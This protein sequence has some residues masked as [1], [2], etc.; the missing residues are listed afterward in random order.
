MEAVSVA[1][2]RLRK[3]LRGRSE[4]ESLPRV[5][6]AVFRRRG[7]G[8]GRDDAIALASRLLLLDPDATLFGAQ[9]RSGTIKLT[10]GAVTS[11]RGVLGQSAAALHFDALASA[12][13]ADTW[14]A[15]TRMIES[16]I[17]ESG[18]AASFDQAVFSKFV[19]DIYNSGNEDRRQCLLNVLGKTDVPSE[20]LGHCFLRLGHDVMDQFIG[21]ALPRER[22]K[23]AIEAAHELMFSCLADPALPPAPFAQTVAQLVKYNDRQRLDDLRRLLRSGR[24]GPLTEK[25]AHCLAELG[26][27][28][29][30]SLFQGVVSGHEHADGVPLSVDLV[31]QRD[32][33]S[34]AP[35]SHI[36]N[37]VSYAV[38]YGNARN[39]DDLSTRLP[40][41][42]QAPASD[43][44]VV[45]SDTAHLA[46]LSERPNFYSGINW[47]QPR[48]HFF[49]VSINFLPPFITTIYVQD[50][51]FYLTTLLK[52]GHY[53]RVA[54]SAI[55]VF[56]V[57]DGVVV[58]RPMHFDDDTVGGSQDPVLSDLPDAA[59]VEPI[60]WCNL[61]CQYCH[62]SFMHDHKPDRITAEE[63][64]H[65]SQ[66]RGKFVQIGAAYEPTLNKDFHKFVDLFSENG[67]ELGVIT[68]GSLLNEESIESLVKSN[69]YA[70]QFSFD[71]GT[72][73]TYELIRRL[74]NFETSIGNIRRLKQR[75]REEGKATFINLSVVLM[76]ANIDEIPA[77]IDLAEDL[78]VDGLGF[79]FMVLRFASD[80]ALIAQ[81]LDAQ[82]HYAYEKLDE[83]AE[84]AIRTGKT[85]VL[86]CSYFAQTP[87]RARYPE[88]CAIPGLVIPRPERGFRTY[89]NKYVLSQIGKHPLMEHNCVS[90]F[91]FAR[92]NADGDVS[93]CRDFIIGNVK[94]TDLRDV[95]HSDTARFVRGFLIEN[96][97]VCRACEHYKYCLQPAKVDMHDPKHYGNNVTLGSDI[98]AKV[99]A[100]KLDELLH[101][102]RIS[103]EFKKAMRHAREGDGVAL[104]RLVAGSP[105]VEAAD[106]Y[107][108]TLLHR[109]VAFDCSPEIV[110]AL[111]DCGCDVNA[112]NRTEETPLL[113]AAHAGNEAVIRL[114]LSRGAERTP[115]L[116]YAVG[117]DQREL[118]AFLV[119]HGADVNAPI[120]NTGTVLWV[121]M[122]NG[123]DRMVR[124]LIDQKADLSVVGAEGVSPLAW[125]AVVGN[126]EWA[127]A[128]LE[129]GADPNGIDENGSTPLIHA[130]AQGAQGVA[131]ILVDRGARL[132]W[133]NAAGEDA[134]LI[135]LREHHWSTADYLIRHGAD[136]VCSLT[137][138]QA[139]SDPSVSAY[140]AQSIVQTG[141]AQI[142]E[143][144]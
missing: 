58:E 137:R 95:W 39:L 131:E 134:L 53:P 33:H 106:P 144:A 10:P 89:A 20:L 2:K 66:L 9:L 30:L 115:A 130:A 3:L 83:G 84:Y 136:L 140:L 17:I 132:D 73:P 108:N 102:E 24:L 93:L 71:A 5:V 124:L 21:A 77:M 129:A 43:L 81:S 97:S 34:N 63:L 40:L 57:V 76:R 19:S 94:N 7:K 72:K 46:A 32:I 80:D 111:V 12:C 36:I 98:T 128:M 88:N 87:L 122:R 35:P 79:M 125:A 48:E 45:L 138:A 143:P 118:A 54:S 133:R 64:V 29:A 91:K 14:Q 112:G 28:E 23:Q 96:Q 4:D 127:K 49:Y 59:E 31:L 126:A 18:V 123:L 92:I 68:N 74:S 109:A 69:L 85:V 67:C 52:N 107:G 86:S 117:H 44:F 16:D 6:E 114:L 105:L 135:A 75:L 141:A 56:S 65:L 99:E 38:A 120:G 70:I 101:D 8:L 90:P 139:N 37:A 110:A 42:R 62:V 142:T 61:R 121:A 47:G 113:I 22:R 116:Q 1:L 11:A 15:A 41:S 100:R 78:E 26:Y 60:T 27:A 13:P 51:P 55:V 119:E 82:L 104:A 25:Y 50:D 103:A